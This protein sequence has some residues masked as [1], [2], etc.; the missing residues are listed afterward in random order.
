[1]LKHRLRFRLRAFFIVF[2]VLGAFLAFRFNQRLHQKR[3]ATRLE[4]AGAR[5]FY[6]WQRPVFTGAMTSVTPAHAR[7][8][9]VLERFQRW[10]AIPEV[11]NVVP[12][13]YTIIYPVADETI[14]PGGSGPLMHPIFGFLLGEHGDVAITGVLIP[15]MDPPLVMSTFNDEMLAIIKSAGEV[16]SILVARPRQYYGV[17]VC[18]WLPPDELEKELKDL[19][20]ETNEVVARLKAELPGVEVKAGLDTQ[21][22]STL[23]S[24]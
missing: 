24:W 11:E 7:K 17:K 18:S 12:A 4:K 9:P 14:A 6:R 22:R 21:Q 15:A 20:Q 23:R 3:V 1:M 8:F 5:V 13:Y 10:A 19:S 16:E 2:T